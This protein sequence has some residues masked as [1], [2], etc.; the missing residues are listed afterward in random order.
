MFQSWRPLPIALATA[1]AG[2]AARI[3]AGLFLPHTSWVSDELEYLGAA[4]MAA[5]GF[6]LGFYDEAPWLRPPGYI[7]FVAAILGLAGSLDAVYLVQAMLMS[8]ATVAITLIAWETW[9]RAAGISAALLTNAYYPWIVYPN[10]LLTESLCVFLVSWGAWLALRDSRAGSAGAGI[11]F[12]LASLT[13]GLAGALALP[14]VIYCLLRRRWI[15]AG[16]L[17]LFWLAVQVPWVA[18]NYVA[19][20]ALAQPDLTA[21]YNLWFAA[22]GVRGEQRLTRDLAAISNPIERDRFAQAKALE[23]IASDPERYLAHGPKEA[24]DLWLSNFSAEERLVAGFTLGSVPPWHLALNFLLGD[25]LFAVMLGLA[26]VGSLLRR[27]EP[28]TWVC[29]LWAAFLTGAAFLLF[30]T[31]RFRMLV[32]VPTAVLASGGLVEVTRQLTGRVTWRL[33]LIAGMIV[34]A[35]GVNFIVYPFDALRLGMSRWWTVQHLAEVRSW[36]RAGEAFR[37]VHEVRDLD[38][39]FF[40][41]RLLRLQALAASG[42]QRIAPQTPAGLSDLEAMVVGDLWR[43]LGRPDKAYLFLRSSQVTSSDR[44]DWLWSRALTSPPYGLNLGT[45]MDVGFIKGFQRP[46]WDGTRW[47]RWTRG[48][49]TVVLSAP[50]GRSRIIVEMAAYRPPGW[51]PVGVKLLVS[52][53]TIWEGQV[54]WPWQDVVAEVEAGS[55]PLYL[56][57]ASDTFVPGF[58]D[59]RELGVMVSKINLEGR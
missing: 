30:A 21:G 29:L 14:V 24:A 2:L 54:G 38:A 13:R 18:R 47:F 8:A 3:V 35:F 51:P 33:C 40:E 42:Q 50:S 53:R 36:V 58:G 56:S 39:S 19:Y 55:S 49:A 52:G 37:A 26:L 31:D 34:V 44:T 16:L 46:E 10:L 45:G 17:L 43:Y 12:G 41:T 59:K 57:I 6:G 11:A 1:G 48:D 20:G 22:E 4:K 25:V 5:A 9:G 7:A 15:Q 23:V 27:H 28:T 32:I